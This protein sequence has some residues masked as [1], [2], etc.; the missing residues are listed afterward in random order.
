MKL[1]KLLADL[2]RQRRDDVCLLFVRTTECAVTSLLDATVARCAEIFQVEHLVLRPDTSARRERWDFLSNWPVGCNF[3]FAGAAEHFV[4]CMGS[5]WSTIFFVDGGDGVPLHRDWIDCLL[6]D[7]DKTL[8]A[9]LS[10]TGSVFPDGI[11]RWHVNGNVVMERSFLEAC[12]E[13]LIMPDG[14]DAWDVHHA[15]LILQHARSSTLVACGWR[16]V[17]VSPFHFPAVAERS[18]WWHGCKDGNFVDM[19]REFIFKDGPLPVIEDLGKASSLARMP[20]CL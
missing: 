13:V 1:A 4:C 16:Q 2:E 19:A 14:R 18:A 11:G 6:T 8:Q 10:V 9:G 12:P 15:P 17:G 3:L 5:Q 20:I 7:H